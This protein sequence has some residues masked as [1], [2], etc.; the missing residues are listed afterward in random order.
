MCCVF[1]QLHVHFVTYSHL[2]KS[3]SGTVVYCL[4]VLLG[5][6]VI[7]VAVKSNC[8]AVLQMPRPSG[9]AGRGRPST[10]LPTSQSW[11]QYS[12]DASGWH[13]SQPDVHS[14]S[15]DTGAWYDSSAAMPWTQPN[16]PH[17]GT[18]PSQSSGTY[19][20]TGQFPAT[21]S[22]TSGYQQQNIL[23]SHVV[24]GM[25]TAGD[26]M[27]PM[28]PALSSGSAYGWNNADSTGQWQSQP[29]W[30]WPQNN[31]Q[32]PS[33]QPFQ[34]VVCSLCVAVSCSLLLTLSSPVVSNGYTTKCSKPYWSNP[35][36]IFF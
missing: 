8:V 22:T 25:S 30:P 9:P 12:E 5:D 26:G 13:S 10:G 4:V 28:Q 31:N 15:S 33:S 34:S 27:L 11:P 24:P 29:Q 3:I 18:F 6:S 21:P 20:A 2:L 32:W 1:F 35:P 16:K 7:A 36:F 14:Y 19:T 17:S 23:S